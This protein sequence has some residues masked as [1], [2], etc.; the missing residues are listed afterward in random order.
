MIQKEDGNNESEKE[1]DMVII[2]VSLIHCKLVSSCTLQLKEEANDVEPPGVNNERSTELREK[3][4][5]VNPRDMLCKIKSNLHFI[6]DIRFTNTGLCHY[7]ADEDTYYVRS[8]A[9]Q[10]VYNAYYNRFIPREIILAEIELPSDGKSYL[11]VDFMI[12]GSRRQ[13][14]IARSANS[15]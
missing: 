10:G 6:T 12:T 14:L 4:N 2:N 3:Y 11:T 9:N 5:H 1:D 8:R 13:N 7:N 15:R